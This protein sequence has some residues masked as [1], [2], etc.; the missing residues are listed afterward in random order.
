MLTRLAATNFK[1]FAHIDIPLSNYTLLSGLNST[2]KSTVLQALALLRQSREALADDDGEGLLLNGDL[3]ELGTARDVMHEAYERSES[4]ADPQIVVT[5]EADD[6]VRS[7]AVTYRTADSDADLLLL[8]DPGGAPGEATSE[9]PPTLA[10]SGFQYLRADRISPAT[11]YP[12]S[13]EVAVQRG[14]LGAHGEH[15]VNYLRHFRGQHVAEGL[16]H[17][18]SSTRQLGD[19][20]DAWMQEICPGVSL[21]TEALAGADLVQLSFQFGGRAGVSSTNQYRPTN[22]GFGL[23]YV[24]PVVVACLAAHRGSLL[25]IENPEAHL[26]PRGQTAMATLTCAAAAAGAQVIIE[27]H[28]DHVLNGLRLAVKEELLPAEDVTV[29]FFRRPTDGIGAEVVQPRLGSNGML[30][31]WPEAFFDEW[32]RS[33]L[34]LVD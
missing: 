1:A 25:L 17:P 7:W 28:S 13:R 24:L 29:L 8:D 10:G 34:K 14:F 26:H 18:R 31:E 3:V 33:L 16:H 9:L 20:V 27:T 19:E 22:V 15:T 32:E 11:V 21:Q 6:A 2:G 23:S 5:L 30:T 4:G 12:R